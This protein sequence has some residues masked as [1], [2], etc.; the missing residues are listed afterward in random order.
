MNVGEMKDY[1]GGVSTDEIF[2]HKP[3]KVRNISEVGKMHRVLNV[4]IFFFFNSKCY[5]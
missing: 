4:T 5:S 3:W 1:P 2:P